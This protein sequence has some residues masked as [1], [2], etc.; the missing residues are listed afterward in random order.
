MTERPDKYFPYRFGQSLMEYIGERWGDAALGEI[1]QN[2]TT[3]GV[4]RAFQRQLGLTLHELSDD[5]REAV[6]AKYLPQAAM[7][8]RPRTF[9][10][11]LLTERRSGGQIFLA[12]R[13]SN[14]GQSHAFLSNGNQ[15]A[16]RAVHD[17]WLAD[18]RTGKRIKRLSR[19]RRTRTS[20]SSGFSITE[21][22]LE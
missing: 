17:L 18:A 7:L 20:R 22:L 8:D 16:R 10:Q 9:A 3:L 2:S 19:V 21:R 4:A 12:P 14:D 5:W 11:P 13:W 6:N 15:K 1:L